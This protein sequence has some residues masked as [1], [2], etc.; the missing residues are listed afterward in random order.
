M[1]DSPDEFLELVV[2]SFESALTPEETRRLNELLRQD[3]SCRERYVQHCLH[4]QLIRKACSAESAEA[5]MST[6]V[7]PSPPS[8]R[9]RRIP[10]GGSSS[11]P[12]QLALT[13]AGVLI[14]LV[15][16]LLLVSSPE[17]ERSTARSVRPQPPKT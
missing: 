1:P 5:E 12:W 9:R 16:L 10:G 13:A 7:R 3:A 17:Q 14:G 11:G 8:T 15:V 4:A 2:R 6:P